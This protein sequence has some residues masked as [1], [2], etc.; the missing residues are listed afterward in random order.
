[1]SVTSIQLPSGYTA[2]TVLAFDPNHTVTQNVIV[3]E[4]HT[5]SPNTGNDPLVI[6]PFFAPYYSNG[7]SVTYTPTNGTA[8]TLVINVDYYP[9]MTFIGA[10]RALGTSVVGALVLVDNALSGT[11][12]VNYRSMGGS[13]VYRRSID[14]ANL[15]VLDNEPSITA[16]E[17][18]ANYAVTFPIITSAWDKI[19][20][21]NIQ[22][23]GTAVNSL[24]SS[25]I[26]Q[27][28]DNTSKNSS[29]ITHIGRK[30]NPHTTYKAN[31]GLGN[32]ANYP[33]STD[34]Q[35]AD[36]T[37]NTSYITPAQLFLA[38]STITPAATDTSPGIMALN[39]GNQ[40][41]DANSATEGLTAQGFYN[42]ASSQSNQLGR[43]VNH[44]QISA[45][46][47]PWNNLWPIWWNGN[48]Y[49]DAKQLL[50]GLQNYLKIR[51]LEMNSKTGKVWFPARTS[52]PDL[53]LTMSPYTGFAEGGGAPL[54]YG[55]FNNI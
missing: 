31:V 24:I 19:D 53:T 38:F 3:D 26:A 51:N 34:Q 50:T 7:M 17:Q 48:P 35:A 4:R 29:A 11:I 52:I 40:L 6:F 32:V 30:D 2:N 22:D 15:F 21:A 5:V 41:S 10:T 44:A 54:G 42:L 55:L 12:S 25:L 36:P 13:W 14:E 39:L 23:V 37:N 33:P 47:S 20:P 46:F 43:A 27:A 49:A 1:M 9:A 45:S 8:R 18:Y 28:L 16:W